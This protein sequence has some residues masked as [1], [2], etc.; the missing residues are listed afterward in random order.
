M[1]VEATED[2]F[3]HEV[4]TR[5]LTQAVLVDF[6]AD[7]CQPCHALAPVI[8]AAVEDRGDAVALVKVDVDANPGLSETYSVSGIPAVKA[9]RDGRVVAQFTG[10]R[11][12]AALDMFLDELLAP[13]RADALLDEL[14]ASGELPELVE[15][16]DR[17]DVEGALQFI[18]DAVPAAAAA[19]RDRLREIA[20]ALFER[21]GPDDPLTTIYRRRLAAALY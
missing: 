14:R 5:S 16:L 15:I 9:F 1:P 2:T 6:W 21:L 8:E 4:I 19:D 18:V 11:S 10:V 20:V 12:R 13:P 7:W 3:E 17:D